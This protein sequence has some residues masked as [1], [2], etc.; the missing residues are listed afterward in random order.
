MCIRDRSSRKLARQTFY[1]MSRW[2]AKLEY[3]QVFLSRIVDIGAELFAIAAACTRAEMLRIDNPEQGET[4]Y[5]L[6]DAC[7]QH[8]RLRVEGLF[9]R[10]WS[11][12]DDL[13]EQIARR[14]LDGEFTWLEEGVLDPSEGTGPWI[15]TWEPG[16]SRHESVR[17]PVR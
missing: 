10:L 3:K 2:Q 9:D 16:P 5:A 13:D 12:T 17:R 6:A 8:A 11:N 14:V 7:C 1:G 15:S 4:A